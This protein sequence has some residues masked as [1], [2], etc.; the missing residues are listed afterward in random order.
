MIVLAHSK[1]RVLYWGVYCWCL[2]CANEGVH[3]WAQLLV[4]VDCHGVKRVHKLF[5]SVL[6]LHA[7]PEH[8]LSASDGTAFAPE[9]NTRGACRT[10][11][12]QQ[13]HRAGG[14]TSLRP[15][16]TDSAASRM[17]ACS[18]S[19]LCPSACTHSSSS[20]RASCITF[21]R[22]GMSAGFLSGGARQQATR[23]RTR[24]NG[25]RSLNVA[26][27][28]SI[29]WGVRSSTMPDEVQA[30]DETC[31]S[32]DVTAECVAPRSRCIMLASQSWNVR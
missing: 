30:P 10:L 17:L 18:G 19:M 28:A 31:D 11:V 20:C 24:I 27:T 16:W 6:D 25:S 4:G 3:C 1:V 14:R 9:C 23:N 12:P 8:M 2:A 5:D 22:P 26:D 7:R 13:N 21:L 29:N 15:C 32:C